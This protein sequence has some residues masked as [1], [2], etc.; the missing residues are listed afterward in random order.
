M[1]LHITW[2]DT[3][4]YK[5]FKY[6]GMIIKRLNGGWIVEGLDNN[7]YYSLDCSYN[8]IDKSLGTEPTTP[9]RIKAGIKIIGKV[10]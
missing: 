10:E 8:A 9:R 5:D 6:K 3:K 7:I 2:K 1:V 4:E